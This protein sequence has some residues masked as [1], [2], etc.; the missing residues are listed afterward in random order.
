MSGLFEILACTSTAESCCND[1]VIMNFLKVLI[2]ILDIMQIIVP[3]ILIVMLSIQLTKLVINPNE[4]KNVTGLKN[5]IIGTVVFFLL[6]YIVN[7]VFG[8][9][10]D[11]YELSSCWKVAR[12]TPMMANTYI[13]TGTKTTNSK[14]TVAKAKKKKLSKKSLKKINSVNKNKRLKSKNKNNK[15]TIKGSKK[16]IKIVNYA[17]MF[18]G[19]R[20]IYGGYW[21]G[22]PSYTGT[23]CSGFVQGVF[24]HFGINLP[25]SSQAQYDATNLYTRVSPNDIRAGDIVFYSGHVAIL[26]GNGEEIVHASNERNGIKLSPT[27]RYGPIRC[28]GRIKGVN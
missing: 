28:I 18:V 10:P 7:A 9:V 16:G 25:R 20:Y 17:R 13:E 3:I 22:S 12:E 11:S 26:T 23:D 6:P 4:K 24:K 19:Q 14:N 8:L 2:R 15:L 27:Y 1:Y 21:N 5:E